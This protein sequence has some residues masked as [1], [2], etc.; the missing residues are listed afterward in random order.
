MK[1]QDINQE[2]NESAIS[3]C[4]GQI[5]A[6]VGDRLQQVLASMPVLSS[7]P[8]KN[9]RALHLST[10]L[11]MDTLVKNYSTSLALDTLCSVL[12][13]LPPRMSEKDHIAK[14]TV[15]L[16]SSIS[17]NYRQAIPTILKT[18][19][20]EVH[21]LAESRILQHAA[22][23]AMLDFF[24]SVLSAQVPGLV[25]S[26]LPA[27]LVN[28]ILGG[29][30]GPIHKQGMD[31]I[32]KS[33]ASLVSHSEREGVGAVN[34]FMGNLTS[35]QKDYSLTFSSVAIGETGRGADLSHLGEH[36]PAILEAFNP[37]SEMYSKNLPSP[38]KSGLSS[39]ISRY[40]Y[41]SII[42]TVLLFTTIS[43]KDYYLIWFC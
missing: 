14:L 12:G 30:G 28:P 8:R 42:D 15:N 22:L 4:T 40:Y 27:L 3:Y 26:D 17:V 18:V 6:H 20:P 11:L 32:A 16:F 19:L 2:V 10:L 21:K 9:Q 33:V 36:K 37:T 34:Q 13:E 43:E 31:Y 7:F 5:V 23:I 29:E 25:H 38:I 35:N 39:W 24:K 1:A 41:K